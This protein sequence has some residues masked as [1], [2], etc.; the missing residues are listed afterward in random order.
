MRKNQQNIELFAQNSIFERGM[1]EENFNEE[2]NELLQFVISKSRLISLMPRTFKM[3]L[4][5]K[6]KESR[7]FDDI[8]VDRDSTKYNT[9]TTEFIESVRVVVERFK[10]EDFNSIQTCLSSFEGIGRAIEIVAINPSLGDSLIQCSQEF[11]RDDKE[12]NKIEKIMSDSRILLLYQEA[13]QK[14]TVFSAFERPKEELF[15]DTKDYVLKGEEKGKRLFNLEDMQDVKFKIALTASMDMEG[16]NIEFNELKRSYGTLMKSLEKIQESI[17]V[18]K[19]RGCILSIYE[20]L[21]Q[22]LEVMRREKP[23]EREAVTKTLNAFQVNGSDFMLFVKKQQEMEDETY[24]VHHAELIALSLQRVVEELE[25]SD[26]ETKLENHW[27]HFLDGIQLEKLLNIGRKKEEGMMDRDDEQVDDDERAV[28]SAISMIPGFI[29]LNFEWFKDTLRGLN[30]GNN[31]QQSISAIGQA[32]FMG[33]S[34]DLLQLRGELKIKL[35]GF[36]SDRFK[37]FF[38][39]LALI[40]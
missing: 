2:E 6:D 40:N 13:R 23:E 5:F 32:L 29:N 30:L 19:R 38:D 9:L 1:I 39:T 26:F 35:A 34:I 8:I 33:P 12:T 10:A 21:H 31:Y 11:L 36:G 25:S 3:I 28:F 22:E 24:Y 20:L 15:K 37:A 16:S 17:I 18:I 27:M 14:Y 4:A 7:H